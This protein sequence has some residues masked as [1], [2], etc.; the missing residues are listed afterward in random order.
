VND[1]SMMIPKRE[2]LQAI[3]ERGTLKPKYARFFGP[4]L[5][6]M[7]MIVALCAFIPS[8]A[9]FADLPYGGNT[10]AAI[11]VFVFASFTLAAMIPIVL[12]ERKGDWR[13]RQYRWPEWSLMSYFF[14]VGLGF[15]WAC[16]VLWFSRRYPFFSTPVIA[17][18]GLIMAFYA[19]IGLLVARLTGGNWRTALLIF[20]FAPGVLAAIV[21]RLGLL[22]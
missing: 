18:T 8:L 22:R 11:G 10:A 9:F 21:L 5:F 1:D 12:P 6:G 7:V 20:A 14:L 13:A 19:A 3:E 16:V 15:N 4:I 17:V 2:T